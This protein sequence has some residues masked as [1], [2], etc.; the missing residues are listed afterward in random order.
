LGPEFLNALT[1]IYLFVALCKFTLLKH[2]VSNF[3]PQ[4]AESTTGLQNTRCYYAAH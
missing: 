1:L 3:S 4:P 2:S